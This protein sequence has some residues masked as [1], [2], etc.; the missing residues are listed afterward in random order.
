[1]AQ[2]PTGQP[3][4]PKNGWIWLDVVSKCKHVKPGVAE[5]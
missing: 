3:R 5:E 1:L 4:E 2:K